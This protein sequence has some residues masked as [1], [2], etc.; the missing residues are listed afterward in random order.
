MH[1]VIIYFY[2]CEESDYFF[3]HCLLLRLEIQWVDILPV[4]TF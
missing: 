2:L 3:H 1:S 4:L